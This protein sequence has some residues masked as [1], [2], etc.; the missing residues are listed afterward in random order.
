VGNDLYTFFDNESAGTPNLPYSRAITVKLDERRKIA[1]LVASDNQ[2]EGLSA[3]SQGNA[4][5]TPEGGLFVG[6]GALPYFSEFD[7]FGDLVFNAEFPAGVNTYRAY[8]LPWSAG[9]GGGSGGG[10]GPGHGGSGP[11]HGG[12]GSPGHGG[13]KGFRPGRRGGHR[14]HPRGRHSRR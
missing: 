12:S 13:S 3:A 5:E 8:Q 14:F 9:V 6:W 1:T 2:P 4:Q 10:S 11:G 7:R